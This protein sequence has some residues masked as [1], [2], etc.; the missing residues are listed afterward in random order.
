MAD[1][2]LLII[3]AGSGNTILTEEFDHWRVAIVERDRFGGTCLNRGCIPSKMLVVPANRVIDSEESAPLGIGFAPPEIDWPAM[4]DRVFGRIDPIAS[5]GEEYRRGLPKVTVLRGDALMLDA[6][7][8]RV[9]SASGSVEEVTSDRIVLAAGASPRIPG[10]DGL[11]STPFHTSDSIMRIEAVPEHLIIL[12]GGFI[13]AELGHVFA[14]L[15]SKVSIVHRGGRLLRHLDVDISTRFTQQFS[16]RAFLHLDTEVRRVEH[17][18]NGFTL[19]LDCEHPDRAPASETLTGDAL[20]VTTGRVP[21]GSH[22]GVSAAGV[23]L[24]PGGYVITDDTLFTGV[25][26]IWALGD[27]RNPLQLKH[28]ANQ[29]ARVVSHNLLH[30]DSPIS[31]DQRVVPHAV[32]SHPEIGAVGARQVDLDAR[33]HPY[34]VGHCDYGSVAYGWALEDTSGF[35]K[36]LVCAD[37]G[38]ILGA[39]VIG[40]QAATLVQQVTQAMQFGIPARSLAREQIWC[41]PALPEVIENALLNALE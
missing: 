25:P 38:V 14:A 39:H 41:H 10:I 21:N 28:L 3:G 34:R 9:T 5:K 32:F 29:E 4:R 15:G 7:R 17:D 22:L 27:I 37:E 13:A 33:G 11:A 31:V 35:A 8:V 20:L 36:V 30:P 24:D 2:D 12:G 16:K 1:F 23:H 40:H 18:G 26:G 19:T 6:R